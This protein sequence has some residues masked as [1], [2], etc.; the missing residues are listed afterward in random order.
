MLSLHNYVS[1]DNAD[2]RT[3]HCSFQL[4]EVRRYTH[5]LHIHIH[6]HTC[7]KTQDATQDT[8][9]TQTVQTNDSRYKRPKPISAHLWF[10]VP[11]V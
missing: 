10:R 3:C 9:Q 4:S 2:L 7:D 8:F 1:F 11:Q 6:T 5:L